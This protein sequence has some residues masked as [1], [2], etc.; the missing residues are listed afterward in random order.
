MTPCSLL[1]CLTTH[2]ESNT[3][4]TRADGKKSRFTGVLFRRTK[5]KFRWVKQPASRSPL[6]CELFFFAVVRAERET[7][8]YLL[9][10]FSLSA[11]APTNPGERLAS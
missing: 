5:F 4:S 7:L 11:R 1:L 9:S 2:R 10:V 8:F 6:L 3:H